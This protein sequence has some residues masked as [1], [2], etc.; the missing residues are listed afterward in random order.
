MM[1][2][3]IQFPVSPPEKLGPQKAKK[4]RKKNLEDYGQLNLFDQAAKGK[5]LTI[6]QD[7]FFEQALKL[8]EQGSADAIRMYKL[9]IDADQSVAD[10]HCNL[11][12]IY[13]K[14]Q[15]FP[16]AIDH[17]SKCLQFQPRHFEAHYNLGNVY[18][19]IGNY[20]LSKM[21]C[22]VAIEI[23]PEF[24][25]SYYNLALVLISSKHYKEAQKYLQQYILLAPDFDHD[26]AQDLIKTLDSFN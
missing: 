15:L 8:D 2:K 17:L 10:A 7:N 6:K 20:P 22:K 21:H 11:G 13:S 9:A 24:P 16:K 25:N 3:V 18:S 4:R 26:A 14:D 23:A 5:V 12:I 1:A 19:D